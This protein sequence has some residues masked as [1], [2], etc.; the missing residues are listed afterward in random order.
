MVVQQ[1]LLFPIATAF[2]VASKTKQNIF[3]NLFISLTYNSVITLVAAGL[4]I[5]LGFALNPALGVALMVLESAIVLA[6][7]YRLK[8]QKIVSL[9]S[10]QENEFETTHT[11]ETTSKMLN[12]LGFNTSASPE[13]EAL[14]EE[15]LL[16][17]SIRST[18]YGRQG[19]F[20]GDGHKKAT[21]PIDQSLVFN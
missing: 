5:A 13:R 20:F 12:R 16:T 10:N 4:F 18:P 8:H 9:A 14:P 6:N 21:C 19:R 2:D 17:S 1:G 3:Q 11:E 15:N 7:L